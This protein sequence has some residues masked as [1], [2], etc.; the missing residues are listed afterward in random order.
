MTKYGVKINEEK[1][2]EIEKMLKNT[3]SRAQTRKGS[4]EDLAAVL[5]EITKKFG[6]SKRALDGCK[7]R[8]NS[9]PEDFPNAYL[10]KGMPV[11][12]YY[13]VQ[14]HAGNW[15]LYNACRERCGA[16]RVTAMIITEDAKSALVNKYYKF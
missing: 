7:F 5:Q 16:D 15:Y 11:S 9:S 3:N 12:T 13:Y 2:I 4:F 1:R 8:V 6:I 10:K 14:M